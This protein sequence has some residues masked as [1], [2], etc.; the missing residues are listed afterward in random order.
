[1]TRRQCISCAVVIAAFGLIAAAAPAQAK[2]PRVAVFEIQDKTRQLTKAQRQQLTD[3]LSSKI[4]DGGK[5]RVIPGGQ[6]RERLAKKKR[7]SYKSCYD[8]QCQIDIGRELA[9]SKSLA[10]QVVRLGSLCVVIGT[11]FD[12]KSA[13]T[14]ASASQ[15]TPCGIELLAHAVAKVSVKLKAQSEE[16]TEAVTP[17]MSKVEDPE[18]DDLEDDDSQEQEIVVESMPDNDDSMGPVSAERRSKAIWAYTALGLA[19]ASA[20][21]GG[22]LFGVARSQGGTAQD[23]YMATTDQATMDQYR[24]E[25]ESSNVKIGVGLGLCGMAAA[26][27]GV[28]IYS[29]VTRPAGPELAR[30]SRDDALRVGVIA[31]P[32]GGGMTIWGRF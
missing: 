11:L 4:A 21:A 22:V 6:V 18:S 17:S 24:M 1:M 15:E 31:P 5:F 29:F 32:G 27:L 8:Q 2:A 19:V 9:A 25:M 28:S 13:A 12:L 26:A 23:N 7:E 14:D 20:V 10:T 30:K 3:Y 16:T